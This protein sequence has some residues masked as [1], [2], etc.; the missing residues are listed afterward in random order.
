MLIALLLLLLLQ[1]CMLIALLLLFRSLSSSSL[2]SP[3]TAD[4]LRPV[5]PASPVLEICPCTLLRGRAWAHSDST[6]LC[7][8]C[9][10]ALRPRAFFV[11]PHRHQVAL[12][13]LPAE[14]LLAPLRLLA[15]L[16]KATRSRPTAG[17]CGTPSGAAFF[18]RV[19]FFFLTLPILIARPPA[20]SFTWILR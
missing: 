3:T 10:L 4:C 6:V 11:D 12:V 13:V 20:S 8:P 1:S 9:A 7:R 17:P 15:L 14:L 2:F 5:V 16:S 19:M 18:L